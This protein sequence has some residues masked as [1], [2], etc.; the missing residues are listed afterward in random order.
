MPDPSKPRAARKINFDMLAQNGTRAAVAPA[1]RAEKAYT[2]NCLAGLSKCD[3]PNDA[4]P[5]TGMVKPGQGRLSAGVTFKQA[6]YG[7]SK[8][9]QSGRL[10]GKHNTCNSKSPAEKPK[11]PGKAHRQAQEAMQQMQQHTASIEGGK[12]Q[13]GPQKKAAR[14]PGKESISMLQGGNA[15]GR[16]AGSGS[17][18]KPTKEDQRTI[19]C[20]R[21]TPACEVLQACLVFSSESS[22]GEKRSAAHM[23]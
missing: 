14:S 20:Q 21:R 23:Q 6:A 13:A 8:Q 11:T 12:P 7:S 18:N 17:L 22:N 2:E 3:G 5:D 10:H 19:A 16:N 1:G 4:V 9:P 15:A